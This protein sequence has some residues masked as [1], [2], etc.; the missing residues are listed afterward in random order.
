MTS[1]SKQR[2]WQGAGVRHEIFMRILP[3]LRHDMAGPLSVARMGNAML[4]RYLAADPVDMAAAQRRLEQNDAQLHD[5]LNAIR[6]L[7]R[8]DL[9]GSERQDAAALVSAALQL[10]RPLLDL[11][12]IQLEFVEP[13]ETGAWLDIQPARCLYGVLGA[14]CF[15]QD[16]ARGSAAIDVRSSSDHHLEFHRRDTAQA[17]APEANQP[18]GGISLAV[19][20][21]SK[22]KAAAW[23]PA[24]EIDEDAL[25]SLADELQWPITISHDQIVLHSPPPV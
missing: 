14:V 3:A 7:S 18:A 11:D 13:I 17:Q 22:C 25:A 1:S 4:K 16:G 9:G 15:L 12:G 24:L 20:K 10:A 19:G 21:T 6:S 23:P 5:L 8:W 2:G